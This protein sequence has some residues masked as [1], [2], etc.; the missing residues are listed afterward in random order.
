M[1]FFPGEMK[2]FDNGLVYCC[3]AIG[4]IPWGYDYAFLACPYVHSQAYRKI[5]YVLYN[6]YL[7]QLAPPD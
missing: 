4:K 6:V 2:I 5:R 1:F 3:R 7:F